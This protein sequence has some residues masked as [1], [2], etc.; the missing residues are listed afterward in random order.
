VEVVR[1]AMA[2]NRR[3]SVRMI[4]EETGLDKNAAHRILA[5]HLHMQTICTEKRLASKKRTGWKFVGICW[6]DWKLSQFFWIK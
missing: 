6:Q 2:K 4:A 3:L 1:A 5:D